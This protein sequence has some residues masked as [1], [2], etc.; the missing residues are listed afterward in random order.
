M[1]AVVFPLESLIFRALWIYQQVQNLNRKRL[2]FTYNL[3]RFFLV[4]HK[5]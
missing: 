2:L 3:N 1:F 5:I 4:V